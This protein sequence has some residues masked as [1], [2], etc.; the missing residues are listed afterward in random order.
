MA[1]S[2]LVLRT[3]IGQPKAAQQKNKIKNSRPK[4]RTA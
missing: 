3:R 2:H 4:N 1:S